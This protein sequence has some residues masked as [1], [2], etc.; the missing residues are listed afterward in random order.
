MKSF[1]D[2]NIYLQAHQLAIGIHNISLELPKHELYEEGS[3]IRRSSKAVSTAIVEGYS[4]KKYKADFIKFL[5]YA[6]AE[7]DE[8]VEHR[9]FLFETGSFSDRVR[10]DDFREQYTALGKQINQFIK[11]VDKNWNIF[12]EIDPNLNQ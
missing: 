10:Y 1:R 2:L 11:W 6:Q 5:V 8:T 9:D 3:Q 4:R 12:P 7:C